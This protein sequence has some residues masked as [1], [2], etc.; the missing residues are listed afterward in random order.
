M[1][2]NTNPVKQG[3]HFYIFFKLKDPLSWPIK[4]FLQPFELLLLPWISNCAVCE[5]EMNLE[6]QI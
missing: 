6:I 4:S 5:I 2:V 3:D 1:F